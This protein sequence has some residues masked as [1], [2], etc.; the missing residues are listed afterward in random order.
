VLAL[1]PP[2][3]EPPDGAREVSPSAGA[4]LLD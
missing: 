1:L 3:T 2:G 4:R